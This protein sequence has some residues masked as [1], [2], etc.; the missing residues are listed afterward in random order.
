[1]STAIAVL[2]YSIFRFGFGDFSYLSP[3]EIVGYVIA[4][5][6]VVALVIGAG[7]VIYITFHYLKG[8][9]SSKS[10]EQQAKEMFDQMVRDWEKNKK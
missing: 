10:D 9:L 1:M 3:G 7:A 2:F 4:F 5:V 8:L 6:V